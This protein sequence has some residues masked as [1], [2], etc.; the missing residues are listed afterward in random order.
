[1]DKLKWDM[2]RNWNRTGLRHGLMAAG[3]ENRLAAA[4][5]PKR[6]G[7]LGAFHRVVSPIYG[8]LMQEA[9][10]TGHGQRVG[11]ARKEWDEVRVYH[12]LSPCG[13][14]P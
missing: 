14:V 13:G 1:M 2:E 11:S 6:F 9:S 12:G 4:V 7:S 5:T 10:C 3:S 8:S